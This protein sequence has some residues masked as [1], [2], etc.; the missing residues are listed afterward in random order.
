[1][2]V[3]E[4]RKK[5]EEKPKKIEGFDG[6]IQRKPYRRFDLDLA[7][8]RTNKQFYEIGS[9]IWVEECD[10][11][12]YI[13]LDD[14]QAAFFKLIDGGF[15]KMN[16]YNQFWIKNTAQAGKSLK[17]LI[18]DAR[19]FRVMLRGIYDH[20]KLKNV[21]SDQHHTKTVAGELNLADLLE[22]NHVS[23]ASVTA[24]QHHASGN[25]RDSALGIKTGIKA[26]TNIT[27]A[28]D[29]GYAKISSSGGG[30][31]GPT[32]IAHDYPERNITE[33]GETTIHNVYVI[34]SANVNVATLIVQAEGKATAAQT[35]TLKIYEGAN[36]R[37]TLSWTETTLTCKT[38]TYDASGWANGKHT[39]TAKVYVSGGTGRL[40]MIEYWVEE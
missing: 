31:G 16:E 27:I 25:V 40:E 5:I 13:K 37:I 35:T 23:L 19:F 2:K 39:L 15:Y 14:N 34:K 17:A 7:D 21:L 33:T 36:L 29:A 32:K 1:M 26:G 8:A 12:V 9:F 20:A 10:G 4:R 3:F 11:D 38:G 30:G 24:D 18:G 6:Q 22:K 28:D